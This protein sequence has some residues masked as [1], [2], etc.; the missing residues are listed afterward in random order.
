MKPKIEEVI[1]LTEFGKRY[2]VGGF[3]NITIT[4]PGRPPEIIAQVAECICDFCNAEI[5]EPEMVYMLQGGSHALC[6]SCAGR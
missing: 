2:R 3:A 5:Q 6:K 1:T 4:V